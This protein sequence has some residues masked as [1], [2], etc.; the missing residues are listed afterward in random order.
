MDNG[1]FIVCRASAGS[2]KTFT[3]V[4]TF[5]KLSFDVR[6][7]RDWEQTHQALCD[8]YKHILAITFTN[9]A[10]NEMKSRIMT[11]LNRMA[12][13][14]EQSDMAKAIQSDLRQEGADIALDTLQRYADVV[15]S[16]IL[17]DYSD[18]S[19]CT[20]DKFMH[21]VVRTFAHDLG[22]PLNFDV[23]Q[24]QDDVILQVVN[25]MMAAIGQEG[26]EELT[27]ML[28]A[29]SESQM[30]DDKSVNIERTI[31]N[32]CNELF[33]E[34]TPRY[35]QSLN[36]M[37]LS[38]FGELAS[39]MR[40]EN[41][42]WAESLRK[43]AGALVDEC[44]ALGLEAGDF[45]GGSHSIYTFIEK[46]AQGDI[47]KKLTETV[48]K[49][50]E[51]PAAAGSSKCG[52]A[53]A[54]T[55]RGLKERLCDLVARQQEGLRLY[56]SRNALNSNL[57]AVALL[58]R[59][60]QAT[61]QYYKENEVLH[62][63]EFNHRIAEVVREEPA[64]FIYERLGSRYWNY[65]ID[66][67]QDTSTM[68]WQN[69]L[70]LVDNGISSGHTALIVGDGKQAIY[71]FRQGDARQFARLPQVDDEG[72]HGHGMIFG[73]A[74]QPEKLETNFRSLR[75]VI[76][77]NNNLFYWIAQNRY[78][79]NEDVRKIYLDQH[80][81]KE[82]SSLWQKNRKGGGYVKVA[83]LDDEDYEN[84]VFESVYET[85]KGQIA[86]GYRYR[87]ICLLGRRNSTL[88]ALCQYLS[89]KEID[90]ETIPMVSSESFLLNNSRMVTLML[91]LLRYMA[92]END[93]A[94][95]AQ[96]VL[97]LQET[98]RLHND[99]TADF[100]Q[101]PRARLDEILQSEGITLDINLLL[102]LP[103][104]DCCEEAMRSLGIDGI[105]TDYMA[106]FLNLIAEYS[107]NHPQNIRQFL[108]WYELSNGEGRL[109]AK[110]SDDLD[111][112]RLMTIH[113]A[114]GL[115]APIIIYPIFA[116]NRKRKSEWSLLSESMQ[117]QLGANGLTAALV[118]LSQ[119]RSTLF[120]PLRD[121]EDSN[122]DMDNLNVLYV[123]L[124]RPREKLFL[125]APRPKAK[126]GS[127]EKTAAKDYA[128]ML[129]DFQASGGWDELQQDEQGYHI[130]TDDEKATTTTKERPKEQVMVINRLTHAR[131]SEKIR[132]ALPTEEDEASSREAQR[133]T[134]IIIHEL[135][136]KIITAADIALVMEDYRR[137]TGMDET[138]AEA[139]RARLQQVVATPDCARFFADGCEVKNECDIAYHGEIRR[140]DRIVIAPEGTYVVDFKTGAPHPSHHKQVAEYCNAV[141][142]MGYT[143]VKGYIVYIE[144]PGCHVEEA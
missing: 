90:G 7:G 43:E 102:S 69:L 70:P 51:D 45:A 40:A 23:T 28:V 122:V 84:N 85:L 74:Y 4:K 44:N 66:E 115:E 27:R 136:S 101:R 1:R 36:E 50:M 67:F 114:K 15:R 128:S 10:V 99:H 120:D 6:A 25:E 137:T 33:K 17:H 92:D 117:Q 110:T 103:L 48:R 81:S 14:A 52:E 139:L 105:E 86:K 55:I 111:A 112:M 49:F 64:P 11:E 65:L 42:A 140:P 131:W 119:E 143:N 132:I 61:Q 82:D 38:Q 29:Y 93:V 71:R 123:A 37:T 13:N 83:F 73:T 91:A 9:K 97:L 141:Q 20:I 100:C 134:G 138:E 87:D 126:K 39:K 3:L 108:E 56:N 72:G 22:L 130:G 80:S 32:L 59:L 34:E 31:T 78:A 118:P 21:R 124:T 12:D 79:D 63:S 18:L 104:Y 68:Q 58:N 121:A 116:E 142:E 62:L 26:E 5:L 76:D 89:G 2:G 54:A 8:R 109:S 57:Y 88:S 106:S 125:Y 46:I 107:N 98:E 30:E 133:R 129:H 113:K 95:E 60:K 96:V 24:K 35:L 127:K 94:A 53:K 77:F 75:N 41:K 19:V 135:L 16:A 47:E 144:D